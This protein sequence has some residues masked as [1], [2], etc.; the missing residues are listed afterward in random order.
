MQTVEDETCLP[1]PEFGLQ[2]YVRNKV[3]PRYLT[4]GRTGET[5]QRADG[6]PWE[7]PGYRVEQDGD[8]IVATP[9]TATDDALVYKPDGSSERVVNKDRGGFKPRR[10]RRRAA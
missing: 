9:W 4:N 6:A 8:D 3:D 5:F 7:W 1:A 2:D 10:S